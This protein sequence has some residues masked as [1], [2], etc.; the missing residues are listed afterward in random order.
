MPGVSQPNP[1]GWCCPGW[2][3]LAPGIPPD[4]GTFAALGTGNLSGTPWPLRVSLPSVLKDKD[5]GNRVLYSRGPFNV[6][7]P[8]PD[9][10]CPWTLEHTR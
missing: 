9:E 7:I 8:F 2:G 1:Q 3:G 5:T 6:N 10:E 4:K